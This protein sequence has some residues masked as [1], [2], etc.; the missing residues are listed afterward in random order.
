MTWFYPHVDYCLF[1]FLKSSEGKLATR[2]AGMGGEDEVPSKKKKASSRIAKPVG[3]AARFMAAD[4]SEVTKVDAFSFH[5]LFNGELSNMFSRRTLRLCPKWQLLLQLQL[6]RS[7][8]LPVFINR[9]I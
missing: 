2:H 3:V 5:S 9:Q 1:S 4:V 8:H 6:H 7:V